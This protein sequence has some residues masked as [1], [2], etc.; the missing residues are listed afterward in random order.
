MNP[1]ATVT[2]LVNELMKNLVLALTLSLKAF[3]VTQWSNI[4]LID[5]LTLS[6]LANEKQ[7][8]KRTYMAEKWRICHGASIL[9]FLKYKHQLDLQTEISFKKKI[10][11]LLQNFSG[12]G[13]VLVAFYPKVLTFYERISPPITLTRNCFELSNRSICVLM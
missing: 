8:K 1:E 3:C 4:P 13:L 6:Y 2:C 9:K 7:G 5:E 12:T 10:F 11:L